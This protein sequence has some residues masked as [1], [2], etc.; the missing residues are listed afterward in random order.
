MEFDQNDFKEINEVRLPLESAA[1]T[2]ARPNISAAD[3]AKLS[4][5]KA[6]MVDSYGASKL[7]T[8]SQADMAFHSL[9]WDRTE[10]GR[11][12][13]TLKTL[14]AP[15][16]AYGSLFNIGRPE[17]TPRLLDE[18]HDSFIQFLG[19]TGRQTAEECVRFHL[20]M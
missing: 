6:R 10:N 14:L 13:A 4:E 11:M 3:L 17:L 5:L 15:F 18:E 20:G 16:F 8:C 19:G 9:I 7:L 1:L 2:L 12:A